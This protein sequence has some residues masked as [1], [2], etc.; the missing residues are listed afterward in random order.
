MT[1]H[2]WLSHNFIVLAL[3]VA[4]VVI[5]INGIATGSA[6]LVYRT[7]TKSKDPG[8]YWTGIV[9]PVLGIAGLL[10]GLVFQ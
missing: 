10:Y 3:L 7:Y 8:L 2:S 4:L 1:I 9:V 6:T 5:V